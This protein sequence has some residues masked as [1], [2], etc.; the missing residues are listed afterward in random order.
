VAKSQFALIYRN[1]PVLLREMREAAGLTQRDLAGKVNK[2]QSWVF[3]SEAASRRID[4]AEF[5]E[6][7][8]GCGVDPSEAFSTLVQARRSTAGAGQKAI[9][10]R[11]RHTP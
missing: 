9:E 4:I 6:W 3:K 8:L 11:G 5:L 2:S 7:C 1:V 10:T